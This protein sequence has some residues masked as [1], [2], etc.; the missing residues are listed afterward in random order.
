MKRMVCGLIL[1]GSLV[2]AAMAEVPTTDVVQ[3]VRIPVQEVSIIKRLPSRYGISKATL[4]YNAYVG[5]EQD[6][7][8]ISVRTIGDV[9]SRVEGVRQFNGATSEVDQ[10]LAMGGF[11]D[12]KYVT[13]MV[14]GIR[15]NA[16]DDSLY[17]Y[18]VPLESIGRYEVIQGADS[19]VY[20]SGGFGGT[21]HL[22]RKKEVR[23]FIKLEAGGLGYGAQTVGTG[24]TQDALYGMVVVDHKSAD[25]YRR[26]SQYDLSGLDL[27]Q[28]VYLN[29]E[30]TRTLEYG[31]QT[32][33]GTTNY[34]D[35]LSLDQLAANPIQSYFGDDRRSSTEVSR[36]KY[37]DNVLPDLGFQ[38]NVYQKNSSVIYTSTGFPNSRTFSQMNARGYMCQVDYGRDILL[39]DEQWTLGFDQE[40]GQV[41]YRNYAI[42][43][44]SLMKGAKQQDNLTS[45]YQY[46]YFTSYTGT[47]FD[48]FVLDLGARQDTVHYDYYDQLGAVGKRAQTSDLQARTHHVGV[49]WKIVRENGIYANYRQGFRAPSYTEAFN[50][51]GG[52]IGN[53]GAIDPERAR[54]TEAGVRWELFSG[55][56]AEGSVCRTIMEDEIIYTGWYPNGHNE[57]LGET[58]RDGVDIAL[59]HKISSAFSWRLGYSSCQARILDSA[60]ND[61]NGMIV[62]YVP[63]DNWSLSTFWEFLPR[64]SMFFSHQII[65]RQYQ[66]LDDYNDMDMKPAYHFA[67]MQLKYAQENIEYYLA[68]KNL[69]NDVYASYETCFETVMPA[70]PRSVIVGTKLTF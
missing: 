22:Q 41:D 67:D 46:A 13:V 19:S 61:K 9:V 56:K 40:T 69:F 33:Y 70:D 6:M 59:A 21:V 54:T 65:G 53:N 3:V 2:S 45:R 10:S 16:E 31:Y 64:W 26:H 28:G 63:E 55:F 62:P 57:N 38:I 15:Y 42:D 30:K 34:P 36:L 39:S 37:V 48:R 14:D 49:F 32:A 27:T 18:W 8:N 17:P 7:D 47:A 68:I 1:A 43:P 66:Y 25:G 50:A 52:A 4:P 20:G 51:T 24:W 23:P 29:S 12:P 44:V 58:V 60:G 11:N 35:T 5:G